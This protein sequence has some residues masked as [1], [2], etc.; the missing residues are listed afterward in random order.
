V[1]SALL[2]LASA[3][4]PVGG[5]AYSRGLETA[6][7]RG[8]VHDEASA[9]TWIGE[10]LGRSV[11]GWDAPLLVRLFAAWRERDEALR[12]WTDL[13]DASRETHELQ[14]ES[15]AMG[16]ALARLLHDLGRCGAAERAHASRAHLSAFA[17]AALRFELTLEDALLAYLFAWLEGSVLAAVKLVPLG[18]T[19]G[20]RMLIALGAELPSIASRAR[21]LGDD[22]LGAILPG[23][24]LA[25]ALHE[26]QRT[27]L[28]RS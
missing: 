15:R 5:F 11:A 23:A 19:A 22:E 24:A 8:W 7:E 10:L 4:L 26:T 25:S 17:L 1:N 21:E 3:N 13:A 12:T 16:A 14:R 6:V 9:T 28:F 20:Q 27:R 2:Q 18:Q